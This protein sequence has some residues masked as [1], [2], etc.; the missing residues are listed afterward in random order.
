MEDIDFYD[1]FRFRY[2]LLIICEELTEEVEFDAPCKG[3][4]PSTVY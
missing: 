2:Q 3:S 4:M 1:A